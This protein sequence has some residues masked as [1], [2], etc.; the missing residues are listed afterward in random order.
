MNGR[1][2]LGIEIDP[3]NTVKGGEPMCIPGTLASAYVSCRIVSTCFSGNAVSV[4]KMRHYSL[5]AKT[6][7][8]VE[9][10]LL[11]VDCDLLTGNWLAEAVYP[12]ILHKD[13]DIS[14]V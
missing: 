11:E 4:N 3:P 8:R 5:Q 1:E 6:C 2:F 9:C 10:Y 7:K 14:G 12:A 13:W